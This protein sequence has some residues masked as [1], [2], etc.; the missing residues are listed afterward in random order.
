[1][2]RS[3][4]ERP[5]PLRSLAD[6]IRSPGRRGAMGGPLGRRRGRLAAADRHGRPSG[7]A[8]RGDRRRPG[9]NG[10]GD[11]RASGDRAFPVSL[12]G[13]GAPATP[14]AR[15]RHLL[16]GGAPR[17]AAVRRPAGR[18]AAADRASVGS[19]PGRRVVGLAGAVPVRDRRR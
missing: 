15:P 11:G 10:C 18:R 8:R 6:A 13:G 2:R 5:H 3:G 14:E 7:A 17:S 4:P 16:A 12:R 19:R 1:M 9:R